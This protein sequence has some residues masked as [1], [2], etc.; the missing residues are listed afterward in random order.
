MPLLLGL[1]F[2]TYAT[3]K[4]LKKSRTRFCPITQGSA[5]FFIWIFEHDSTVYSIYTLDEIENARVRSFRLFLTMWPEKYLFAN[6]TQEPLRS[7]WDSAEFDFALSEQWR[8]SDFRTV[9]HRPETDVR[10]SRNS[11]FWTT[12]NFCINFTVFLLCVRACVRADIFT[13]SNPHSY[14][15]LL[16]GIRY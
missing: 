6:P 5:E 10:D 7:I 4:C 9:K 8:L 15:Y 2:I 13:N 16:R 11:Q 3:H 14:K 1:K 12:L